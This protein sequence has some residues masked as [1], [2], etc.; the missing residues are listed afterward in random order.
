MLQYR[1]TPDRDTKLSPALCVFGR[2]IQDFIPIAPGKYKP[3][4]TWW[5]TLKAREEALRNRHMKGAERWS[6]HTKR[7]RPLVIGDHVRIQNQTDGLHCGIGNFSGITSLFI[8]PYLRRRWRMTFTPYV[9][10]P[11]R[12]LPTPAVSTVPLSCMAAPAREPS[13]RVSDDPRSP[14]LDD[15]DGHDVHSP[16]PG[17]QSSPVAHTPPPLP[18]SAPSAS[19]DLLRTPTRAPVHAT[20]MVDPAFSSAP[21]PRRSHRQTSKPVWHADYD[22]SL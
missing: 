6:E 2:P 8:N 7:L 20:D 10:L 19:A 17:V 4:D 11:L 12:L 16:L 22:M 21:S 3:H 15:S 13:R 1:N 9:D 14:I 18:P 5:E